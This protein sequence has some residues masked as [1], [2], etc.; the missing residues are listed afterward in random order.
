M[1]AS[2]KL[3]ERVAQL[4]TALLLQMHTTLPTQ[5][6]ATRDSKEQLALRIVFNRVN[7]QLLR[8]G[9]LPE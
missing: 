4:P 8:R 2:H 9:E 5:I 3:N 7:S 1:D 6:R